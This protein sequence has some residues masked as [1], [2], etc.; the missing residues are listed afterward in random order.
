MADALPIRFTELLQVRASKPV[1]SNEETTANLLTSQ[2]T[3]ADIDV[4]LP[5]NADIKP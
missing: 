5:A 2:L 1:Y 3:S 4:C